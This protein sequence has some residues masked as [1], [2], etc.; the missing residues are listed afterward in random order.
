MDVVTSDLSFI[1]QTLVFDAICKILK[2]DGIYIGLIKPQ[3]EAGRENVGKGGIVKDKKIHERV[4]EGVIGSANACGLVCTGITVSP[5]LG[6]DGNREFLA[7]FVNRGVPGDIPGR[8]V[9]QEVVRK[10]IGR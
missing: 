6:G 7:C 5:I 1:S 3:F 2:P 8:E 4:I 9:I 10:E